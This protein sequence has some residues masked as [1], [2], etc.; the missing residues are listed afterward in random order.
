MNKDLN[1]QLNVQPAIYDMLHN[2]EAEL[3]QVYAISNEDFKRAVFSWVMDKL[4][5]NTPLWM[6]QELHEL[7]AQIE[8]ERTI[9]GQVAE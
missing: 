1:Y 4:V 9:E 6:V 3:A 5:R 8:R 7:Q 2:T